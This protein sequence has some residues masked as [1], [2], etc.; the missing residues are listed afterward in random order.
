MRMT[1]GEHREYPI[2]EDACFTIAEFTTKGVIPN[3]GRQ[4]I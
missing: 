1:T 3:R 4:S 2:A